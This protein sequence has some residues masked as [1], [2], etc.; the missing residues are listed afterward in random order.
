M[1]KGQVLFM[2]DISHLKNKFKLRHCQNM[3]HFN[4]SRNA[5]SNFGWKG[6]I[7]PKCVNYISIHA[8]CITIIAWEKISFIE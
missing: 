8:N 2:I 7:D 1:Q 6:N 5:I 4:S 3:K